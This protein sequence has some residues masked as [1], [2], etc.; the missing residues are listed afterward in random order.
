MQINNNLTENFWISKQDKINV[1]AIKK[2]RVRLEKN[3]L[4]DIERRDENDNE[5]T[6]AAAGHGQMDRKRRRAN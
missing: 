2:F 5:G 6:T 4:H 1:F 3:L